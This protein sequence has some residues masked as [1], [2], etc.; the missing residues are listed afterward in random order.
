[1]DCFIPDKMYETTI[2]DAFNYMTGRMGNP[3][4]TFELF[5]YPEHYYSMPGMVEVPKVLCYADAGLEPLGGF[6]IFAGLSMSRQWFGEL[7]KPASERE[8]WLKDAA[9]QY[10]SL[11]YIQHSV[12]GAAYFSN[13]VSRRDSLYTSR[14]NNRDRPLASGLR[15]SS[16]TRSNKG[17]WLFH[18]LRFM[19]LDMES[20]GESKFMRFMYEL[21]QTC[22]NTIFTNQDVV[23]LAEKHYGQPLDWFFNEWLCGFG[24]PEYKVEYSIEQKP[25][26]YFIAA[27]VVTK[28]VTSDFRMPVILRVK[29]A[30]DESS[31]VRENI[32]G[33]KCSFE[34]GP[35]EAEP[36]E[37]IFNEFYSVLSKDKVKKK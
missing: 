33:T 9:A 23:S 29:G 32:A 3:V 28:G 30:N 27:D 5:V 34:L 22:N 20:Q 11:M 8:I 21:G 7:M 26:G 2:L 37:L 1:M 36:K 10:L 12:K 6:N 15:A 24:Y 31:F 18:M 16:I 19:M 14:G 25:E 4:G 13:L 35:F 17:V